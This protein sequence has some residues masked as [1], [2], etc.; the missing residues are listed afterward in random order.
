MAAPVAVD[1]QGPLRIRL[2]AR[3]VGPGSGVDD[4]FGPQFVEGAP[5]GISPNDTDCSLNA[6]DAMLVPQWKHSPF[7]QLLPSKTSYAPPCRT[8]A[9]IVVMGG[10]N[11]LRE[12]P[13]PDE[14]PRRCVR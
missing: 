8:F 11:R 1:Q 12:P 10:A 7:Q 5:D 13:P 2:A 9:T 4:Q 3:S 6:A 14:V